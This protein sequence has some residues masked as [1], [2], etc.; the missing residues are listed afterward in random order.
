MGLSH[1]VL[2]YSPTPPNWVSRTLHPA[3]ALQVVDPTGVESGTKVHPR[4]LW[5]LASGLVLTYSYIISNTFQHT[6]MGLSG[7]LTS[8]AFVPLAYTLPCLFSLTLMVRVALDV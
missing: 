7:L 1:G 6:F 2:A 8:I 4:Q 5:L 3:P